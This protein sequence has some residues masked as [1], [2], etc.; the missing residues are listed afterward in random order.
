[1]S[2]LYDEIGIGYHDYRRPDPRFAQAIRAALGAARSVLNVGAGT[3]SYEPD[4]CS[5]VAVE[6]SAAMIAQRPAGAAPVVRAYAQ[7]LPFAR[8]S[9][10]TALAVLTL[11]HWPDP[12]GGLTELRRVARDRVVLLTWMSD[13]EPFWL[14]D[15]FPEISEVDAGIFP[16]TAEM[17]GVLGPFEVLPVAVPHD[18]VDGFLGAYWRR[19]HSY[20]DA[21][22]RLAI[23]SFSKIS[24]V[25]EGVERLRSD[26]DTGAWQKRYG[27]L[28]QRSALDLGYRL[29]VAELR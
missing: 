2:E 24:R 20:L 6:P 23:S 25:D 16:S 11:H 3:G 17:R 14:Y 5:V 7:R 13:G 22:A 8:A 29:L 4:H 1:M 26:L 21:G 12:A 27:A 10:D 18:C 28:M 15:Y 19:P 9:F